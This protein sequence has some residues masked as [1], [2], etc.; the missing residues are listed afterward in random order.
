VFLIIEKK[1]SKILITM[2]RKSILVFSMVLLMSFLPS[3]FVSAYEAWGWDEISSDLLDGNGAE[4]IVNYNYGLIFTG[5]EFEQ[6]LAAAN[7]VAFHMTYVPDPDPP[8]DVWTASDQQFAEIT[9]GVEGSGTGDCE[10]FSILVYKAER[11]GIF[12]I[13]PQFGG[14]PYR[15]SYPSLLHWYFKKP[16]QTGESAMLR[17]NDQWVRGGGFWLG[18]RR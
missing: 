5:T 6:V 11:G 17:F 13:E 7:W 10:D 9:P 16:P 14:I 18:G 1:D 12:Y 15:G 4:F 2:K 8:G 3:T